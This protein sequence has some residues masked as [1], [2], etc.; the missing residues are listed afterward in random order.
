[1]AAEAELTASELETEAT[2][3]LTAREHKQL[4]RLLQ[5]VFLQPADQDNL[6]SG[7]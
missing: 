5:K 4:L 1:M 7:A 3:M 6:G 2:S